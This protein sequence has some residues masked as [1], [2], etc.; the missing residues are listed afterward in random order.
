MGECFHLSLGHSAAV[1]TVEQTQTRQAE[2]SRAIERCCKGACLYG[3]SVSGIRI[4]LAIIS[5]IYHD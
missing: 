2:R 5:D 1:I 3:L 4:V